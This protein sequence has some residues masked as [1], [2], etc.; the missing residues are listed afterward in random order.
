MERT[1]AAL[2]L[3][4]LFPLV[5]SV[6]AFLVGRVHKRAAG[7]IA[8]LASILAF[9]WTA[10]LFAAMSA[11]TVLEDVVFSWFGVA[12]LQ[13][14]FTLRMDAL[15]AVMCLV[16]TGIGSLIHIYS[17]AYMA[18]DD[19]VHRFFSYLNL[20]MFSMLLLVLG[21]NLLVLFVG[22]EGVGL[23]SYLLI[24]FWFRT[25]D[26]A[27]AGRKAFVVNRIGDAGFLLGIFLLW[28]NF[29]TV[30]FLE[31]E[32]AI[33]GNMTLVGLCTVVA[34][35]LFIGATGKSAQ[36]PLFVWLPDA[37][38]GPTP[39]SALIHA[40][41]M[42][43]A[44]IYMMARMDFVFALAPF[45]LAIV[46]IVALLTAF[47]AA[48]TALLQND[49]K[50]V[51]A[52]STVSQ[53]GF[54]FLAASAG[55]YWV[56]IFHVVTHA[57]FKACLFLGAGSVIHGCHHEQDMRHMGGLSRY[58]P[59]TFA[60]YLVATLAI[61][62]IFPFAGYQS[63]HAILGA[64]EHNVNPYIAPYNSWIVALVTFTAFLT[65]FYMTRSLAMT[66]F[67]KYRGHAHPHESPAAMSGVLVA[68]AVLSLFGGW[69]LETRLPNF[70][71]HVLA[72][73]PGHASETIVESLLHSW[74]GIAGVVLGLLFYTSLAGVPGLVF[75]LFKPIGVLFQRKWFVD[76]LYQAILVR[77]LEGVSRG[78][79]KAV[80]QGFIDGA[81]NGSGAV[82][83]TSGQVLRLTQS[84][85]VRHYALWMFVATIAIVVFFLVR[86]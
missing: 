13:V 80:D 62:G 37:M 41:T 81:V 6:A 40:A 55:A 32:A 30:D 8:S 75:S 31:L 23:C 38:A 50:K 54:M 69:F 44:G 39:V 83:D 11:E 27:A 9:V 17:T 3:I 60:T 15:G 46:T 20:F 47:V 84:G 18:E 14:D 72:V 52:Y 19:S 12:S 71:E 16:V 77:P 49:I 25:I 42:V 35:C 22:W 86:S 34:L 85:Q 53:L 2:A 64:L 26:Y 82:I 68:L 74:V 29:G 10:K 33:A 57:F 7:I 45:T 59:I 65:A 5:G 4:P 28:M 56:A 48:T 36:I 66:F 78:L 43:T 67:G 1:N 24:G 73:A 61:A 63:K 76:E 70:L 58:M 21:G 51:L 79:W